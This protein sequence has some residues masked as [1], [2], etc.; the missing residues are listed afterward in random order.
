MG[1]ARNTSLLAMV[2]LF[3]LCATVFA[4]NAAP[5]NALPSSNNS[6]AA[7][8]AQSNVQEPSPPRDGPVSLAEAARLARANKPIPE[9]PAKKYDDDNFPHSAPMLKQKAGETAAGNPSPGQLP[10][11]ETRGKVVLLDFWAS[12]CGP[13]RAGLPNLRRLASVYGG[14]DFMIVSISEDQDEATW[15]AFVAAHQMSWPQR[16]DRDGSLQQRFQVSA[17]P[18]YIL[19]DREGHEIQRYVGEDPGRGILERI[20]PEIKRSIQAGL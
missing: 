4:Q 2:L 5:Q 19:L 8:S 18:T 16:Y 3:D 7:T 10:E 14:E 20:G 9:K 6:A 17:L 11:Q 12:W 15:R 1:C 13:C